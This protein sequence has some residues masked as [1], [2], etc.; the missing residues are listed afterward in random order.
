MS[1]KVR[2]ILGALCGLF[3]TFF[4]IKGFGTEIAED[5]QEASPAMGARPA[6]TLLA[7]ILLEFGRHAS[8]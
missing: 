4:A 5:S 7:S 1:W 8:K 2:Q 3:P 6:A